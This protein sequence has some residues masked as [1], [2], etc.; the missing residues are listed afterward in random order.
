MQTLSQK[1]E[2]VESKMRRWHTRLTRASNALRKLEQQRRRLTAQPK[3]VKVT[4][5][6]KPVPVIASDGP[7][8]VGKVADAL[9]IPTF[10]DRANPLVTEEM[11]AKRKA[12]EAELGVYVGRILKGEKPADLPVVQSTKYEC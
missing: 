9:G 12:A 7:N 4:V 10:L 5:V 1:I 6:P 11:T 2:A 3:P 8:L